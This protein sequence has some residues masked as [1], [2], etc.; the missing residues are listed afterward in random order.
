MRTLLFTYK[1]YIDCIN[2]VYFVYFKV[3]FQV[4]LTER[5]KLPFISLQLSFKFPVPNK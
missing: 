4:Y 1:I 3:R 5:Y 2:I